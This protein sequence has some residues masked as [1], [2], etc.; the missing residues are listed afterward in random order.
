MTILFWILV[1]LV[2]VLYCAVGFLLLCIF[3]GHAM[4]QGLYPPPKIFFAFVFGW[5][6]VMV[7]MISFSG[8]N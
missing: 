7:Y 3:T 5:P 6:F 8:K 2:A 4:A 1:A